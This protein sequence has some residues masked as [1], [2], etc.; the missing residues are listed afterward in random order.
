MRNIVGCVL[1]LLLIFTGIAEA[2]SLFLEIEE[3]NSDSFSKLLFLHRPFVY[4][5]PFEFADGVLTVRDN[6]IDAPS[7][8]RE[9]RFRLTIAIKKNEDADIV[10]ILLRH[11]WDGGGRKLIQNSYF[12][13]NALPF[14]IPKPRFKTRRNTSGVS[15][16]T[17]S[18]DM[19]RI[20][21]VRLWQSDLRIMSLADEQFRLHYGGEDILL[22]NGEKQSLKGVQKELRV[23]RVKRQKRF[24][25]G[26]V[27]FSTSLS[28][29]YHRKV[30]VKHVP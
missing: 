20:L 24:E 30:E 14:S 26:S 21:D 23:D 7:D 27:S 19:M 28:V 1:T 6:I 4:T 25:L 29:T 8:E 16:Y 12:V 9:R 17:I 18:M 22:D 15:T 11:I 3:R 13:T 2:D 5:P 10:Y